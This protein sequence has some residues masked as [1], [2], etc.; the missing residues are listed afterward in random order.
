MLDERSPRTWLFGAKAGIPM[1]QTDPMTAAVTDPIPP[2]TTMA[3]R[4]SEPSTR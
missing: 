4:A 2:M 1:T 3:T